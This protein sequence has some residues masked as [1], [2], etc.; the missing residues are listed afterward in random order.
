MWHFGTLIC[1]FAQAKSLRPPSHP[2]ALPETDLHEHEVV[3][4]WEQLDAAPPLK[5]N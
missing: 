3:D 1:N 2:D 4:V 5:H